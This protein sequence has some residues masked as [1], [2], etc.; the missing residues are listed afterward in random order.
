MEYIKLA[1]SVIRSDSLESIRSIGSEPFDTSMGGS[2]WVLG[3]AIRPVLGLT[4]NWR[5]P[6]GAEMRRMHHVHGTDR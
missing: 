5:N 4:M 6:G 1:P 2:R 3:Q